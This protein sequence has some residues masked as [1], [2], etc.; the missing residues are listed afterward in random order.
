VTFDVLGTILAGRPRRPCILS[1][2][3][4]AAAGSDFLFDGAG[5]EASKGL[6]LDVGEGKLVADPR[7]A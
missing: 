5:L 3:P 7:R 6:A 2:R 4:E 1:G